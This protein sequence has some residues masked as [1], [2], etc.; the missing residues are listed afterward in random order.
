V[1]FV[2]EQYGTPRLGSTVR[3]LDG[4]R[5]LDSASTAEIEINSVLNA[6]DIN[7][8]SVVLPTPGGPEISNAVCLIRMQ[9]QRLAGPS[10]GPAHDFVECAGRNRSASGAAGAGFLKRSS[11]LIR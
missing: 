9:P 8:A 7:R 11:T 1:H 2:H 5:I 3:V 10:S 4:S 6:L